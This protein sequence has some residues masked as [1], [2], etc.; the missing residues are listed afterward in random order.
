MKKKGVDR[1]DIE[2]YKGY[3]RLLPDPNYDQ[4]D[5]FSRLKMIYNKLQGTSKAR[6]SMN[7]FANISKVPG[8][9][10]DTLMKP[11]FEI[12]FKRI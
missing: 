9:T 1:H 2:T 11:S 7:K 5:A 6:L 12:I 10:N 4:Y 3:I 8:M